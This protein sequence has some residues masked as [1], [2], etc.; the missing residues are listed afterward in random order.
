[1]TSKRAKEPPSRPPLLVPGGRRHALRFVVLFGLALAVYFLVT[2]TVRFQNPGGA[3]QRPVVARLIAFNDFVQTNFVLPYHQFLARA[4][5]ATVRALG[6]EVRSNGRDLRSPT[7]DFA[8]TITSGCDAIELT[9]L[10]CLAILLFPLPWKRRL[11]GALAAVLVIAVINFVRIVSLW[12]V[13]VNWHPAFDVVHFS[14][15]PFALICAAMAT[16]MLWL[17]MAAPEAETS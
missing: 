13:G 3:S 1:M 5:A 8:V 7:G 12:I 2:S 17:R 4:T 14:V 15:W 6:Y 11:T 10:L 9:L 16:F